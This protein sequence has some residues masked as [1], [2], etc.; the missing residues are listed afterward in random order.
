CRALAPVMEEVAAELTDRLQVIK[1]NIEEIQTL[2]DQYGV[3]NIPT[4]V[5]FR[6]GQEVARFVGSKSKKSL[7]RELEPHL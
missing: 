4:L 2:P 5:L 3:R 7:L 1:V 6:A